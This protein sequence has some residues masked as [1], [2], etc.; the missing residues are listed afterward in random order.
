MKIL[1]ATGIYPPQIG[2]PATY[3]KLLYDELPKHGIDVDVLNFGDYIDRPKIIRHFLYFLELLKKAPSVDVIYAQDP[4]SVGLP[5]LLVSQICHKKFLIRIAGDYAWEQSTQRF[6]VTD[7]I[8][9]FQN[10][11]HNFRTEILKKIQYFV[12]NGA[13]TIITPSLYFKNLV[14]KWC[15]NDSKV[16]VIY[17]GIE[18]FENVPTKTNARKILNIP[19]LQKF[20]T[21]SGRLVPWKGFELLIKLIQEWKT[22]GKSIKLCIMGD[23]PD[24]NRL[25][26]IV[27]KNNLTEDVIFLGSLDRKKMFEQIIASDVFVL[28]TGFES[29]SFQIVEAMRIGTPVVATNVGSIPELIENNKEGI[30]VNFN[31]QNE[32][33]EAVEKILTTTILKREFVK[34]AKKKSAMFSIDNTINNLVKLL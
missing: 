7:S 16:K 2:G 28:N 19:R 3:A 6:G 26:D 5:A 18:S 4:V 13:H 27:T 1:I 8:D 17:N 24:K 14:S 25:T 12:A 23:G 30:L 22:Q 15:D 9:E 32:F 20:I 10:K 34:N 11:K 33:K 31:A 29:F 21:S